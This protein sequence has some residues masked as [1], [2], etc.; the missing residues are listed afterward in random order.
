MKNTVYYDAQCPLC[1]KEIALWRK[2]SGERFEFKDVH[3]RDE[4]GA[5]HIRLNANFKLWRSHPIGWVSYC[6]S[7]PGIYW[8]VSHFYNVWAERRYEKRYGCEQC[9]L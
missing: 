5:W 4:K 6:F 9:Q 3:L 7:I 8:L 1:S 2:L